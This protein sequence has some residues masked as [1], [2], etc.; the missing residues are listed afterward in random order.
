VRTRRRPTA[1]GSPGAVAAGQG[2]VGV[3]VI[4]ATRGQRGWGRVRVMGPEGSSASRTTTALAEWN[5]KQQRVMRRTRL[6]SFPTCWA[7][8]VIC[9]DIWELADNRL[10]VA[11]LPIFP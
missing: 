11:F 1:A 7:R 2:Q 10:L 3:A 5:P 8:G 4:A 9:C 6:L